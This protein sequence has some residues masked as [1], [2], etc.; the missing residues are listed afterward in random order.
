MVTGHTATG[1]TAEQRA[2]RAQA[3]VPMHYITAVS[4]DTHVY[5]LELPATAGAA[6]AVQRLQALPSVLRV[7][8]DNKAKAK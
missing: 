5:G 6:P 7:E 8:V 3:Q 1:I 4:A 2:A